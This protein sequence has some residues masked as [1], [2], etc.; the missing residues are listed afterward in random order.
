MG[1][2]FLFFSLYCQPP[3][4]SFSL[5]PVPYAVRF[6]YFSSVRKIQDHFLSDSFERPIQKKKLEWMMG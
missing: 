4:L 6:S 3:H 5:L 1:L 2:I